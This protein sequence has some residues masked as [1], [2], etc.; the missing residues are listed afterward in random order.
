MVDYSVVCCVSDLAIM[1]ECLLPSVEKCRGRRQLEIIPIINTNNQYSAAIAF[2][3]AFDSAKSDIIIFCHQDVSLLG[4]WFDYL[5]ELIAVASS[6]WGIIGAAGIDASAG[7]EDIGRWGGHRSRNCAVGSVWDDAI[8]VDQI[9]Y[10]D[11][12]KSLTKVHCIDECLFVV[13][14]STNLCFDTAFNGFH[15]YGVD[16]CLQARAAG[17]DVYAGYLPI[18]HA[19][20]YSSSFIKDGRYW[21]F[22]RRLCN[23]WYDKFPTMIGTHMHWLPDA[24]QRPQITSHITTVLEAAGRPPVTVRAMQ[25]NKVVT[26]VDDRLRVKA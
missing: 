11:G 16:L 20:K 8:K 4:A 12:A 10:W 5:D 7:G 3:A 14:R 6:D 25:L 22:L 13:R 23:K 1:S 19:G 9:P 24:E 15:F 21:T 17:L 18:V 2:N 26:S